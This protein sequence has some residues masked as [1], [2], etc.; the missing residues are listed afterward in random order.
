MMAKKFMYVCV[1]LM[2]LAVTFHVGAMYGR[3]DTH[4][5]HETSGIIAYTA[6]NDI[7]Y[8][9]LD[10]GEVWM[11]DRYSGWMLLQETTLPVPIS[12]VKFWSAYSLITYDNELWAWGFNYGA[13]PT[14]PTPTSPTTWGKIKVEFQE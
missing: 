10:N 9:L 3:A 5:D 14:G 7:S 11:W 4:V 12:Q 13:P 2:A 6:L 8:V 1:G